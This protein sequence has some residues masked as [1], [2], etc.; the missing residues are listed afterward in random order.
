MSLWFTK[1]KRREMKKKLTAARD[2][3]CMDFLFGFNKK[4]GMYVCMYER[5][6]YIVRLSRRQKLV[7]MKID[8]SR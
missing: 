2:L 6:E 3:V 8:N 7:L 4:W 5:N 1:Q